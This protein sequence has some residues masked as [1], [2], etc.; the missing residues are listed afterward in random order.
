MIYANKPFI[1]FYYLTLYKGANNSLSWRTRNR[2]VDV[3]RLARLA[4]HSPSGLLSVVQQCIVVRAHDLD[5][6]ART[7]EVMWT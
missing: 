4:C 7:N 2:V 6:T 1:I 3:V 5:Q